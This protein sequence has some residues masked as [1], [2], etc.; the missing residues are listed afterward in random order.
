M[1]K[2]F[3][4]SKLALIILIPILVLFISF[5]MNAFDEPYY[6]QQFEKNNVYKQF[7]INSTELDQVN[8]ELLDYL[9]HGKGEVNI[10]VA[11]KITAKKT[12]IV[13]FFNKKET[14]HLTEVREL[15]QGTLV[16]FYFFLTIFILLTF[17]V[18]FKNKKKFTRNM[19][20]TLIIGNIFNIILTLIISTAIFL[21]F[22]N[23]FT[24]FHLTLFK[25]DTWL[26]NPLTDN[27]IKM[28]P[29]QFFYNIGV[30]ILSDSVIFS[31]IFSLV[32]IYAYVKF[33][34]KKN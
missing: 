27:L 8:T 15:I 17:F 32:L 5:L 23:F 19:V 13:Q 24:K 33:V 4:P 29:Q 2:R 10:T 34:K 28:F 21:N 1:K 31:V 14:I 18:Y 11:Q 30:K 12:S 3:N 16:F 9:K 6:H 7:A 25:T 26:L 20:L 22:S